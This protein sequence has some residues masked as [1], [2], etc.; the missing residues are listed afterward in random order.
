MDVYSLG[1]TLLHML[2]GYPITAPIYRTVECTRSF[3]EG[4]QGGGGGCCGGGAQLHT[5]RLRDLSA[6]ARAML[7]GL[8]K[9]DCDQR[10]TI[11]EC[12]QL[13]FVKRE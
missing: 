5:V 11:S 8:T 13:S 3:D 7:E 6:D 10:P 2:T 4:S 1:R 9:A 12:L